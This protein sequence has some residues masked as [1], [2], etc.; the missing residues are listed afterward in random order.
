[1]TD[2]LEI[3]REFEN[4]RPGLRIKYEVSQFLEHGRLHMIYEDVHMS[5]VIC[6]SDFDY[7]FRCSFDDGVR[8]RFGQ[9]LLYMWE[10]LR[11]IYYKTGVQ[12]Q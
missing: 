7:F 3:L 11:S 8:D 12:S 9:L 2:V 4:D 6:D 5:Y 1:M 10:R